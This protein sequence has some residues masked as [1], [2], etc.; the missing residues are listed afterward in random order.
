MNN[1]AGFGS[2]FVRLISSSSPFK[3][4]KCI[5]VITAAI[6]SVCYLIEKL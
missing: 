2:F 3:Y 5:K 1:S 4:S 6:V